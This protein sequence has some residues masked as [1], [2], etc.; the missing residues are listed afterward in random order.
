MFTPISTHLLPKYI[1]IVVP[2]GLQ[3]IISAHAVHP[4]HPRPNCPSRHS[5]KKARR[6]WMENGRMKT[7]PIESHAMLQRTTVVLL[8]NNP[9]LPPPPT[10]CGPS[11]RVHS[12]ATSYAANFLKKIV[13][14]LEESSAFLL[15]SPR[16]C[17]Y[18]NAHFRGINIP[19]HI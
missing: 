8:A 7:M 1:P 3:W 4:F 17:L 10:D 2:A 6:K 18:A 9:M 19:E 5:S 12:A 11:P 15:I 13:D 16:H 14:D